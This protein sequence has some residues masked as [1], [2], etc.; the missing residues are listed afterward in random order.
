M[1]LDA[2]EQ[3][4]RQSHAEP[5]TT[6]LKS[7][8]ASE[9]PK[10][11]STE[12]RTQKIDDWPQKKRPDQRIPQAR[13]M[14]RCIP[15]RPPIIAPPP[16]SLIAGGFGTGLYPHYERAVTLCLDPAPGFAE[17]PGGGCD[18]RVGGDVFDV[19]DCELAE[20]P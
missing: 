13:T 12:T 2:P 8:W 9:L 1:Q 20:V 14:G 19:E 17:S 3:T 10:R 6:L 7:G 5:A 15:E 16:V 11:G 4:S 18:R